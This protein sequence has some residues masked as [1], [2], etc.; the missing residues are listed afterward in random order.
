MRKTAAE[1]LTVPLTIYPENAH[2]ICN[3]S[4]WYIADE[5]TFVE[6]LAWLYLR[7]PLH[8]KRVIAE[9]A[10]GVAG[11]PGN[12]HQNAIRLLQVDLS[13]I[14]ADLAGTDQQKV[15]SAEHKRVA[16]IAH[17]DGLLFQHISWISA[18]IQFPTARAKPP[19]VRK[20][21]KGFD[22]LIIELSPGQT[23]LTKLIICEDKASENPRPLVTSSIWPEATSIFSGDRDL[24]ILDAVTAM[25]ES[26]DEKLRE[27]ALA[28]ITWDRIR[29]FRVALTGGADQE[30]EGAYAHLF[31]GF[32][33]AVGGTGEDRLAEVMPMVDVRAYLAYL[34]GAVSAKIAEMATN[35]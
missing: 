31:V 28:S 11:F 17:R 6:V 12:E 24:E 5:N 14:A 18:A 19:H 26:V 8:A 33:T 4:R 22:G 20:A 9:L 23:A 10:P 3:L 16:R 35:V 32:D 7:K 1:H 25:L 34:A 15:A 29:K 21:D 30:R 27:E 13:D 2:P